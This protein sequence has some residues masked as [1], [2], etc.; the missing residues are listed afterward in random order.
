MPDE[1]LWRCSF[2]RAQ[3]LFTQ[4]DCPDGHDECPDWACTECGTAFV[5][6][7]AVT[8]GREPALAG[9]RSA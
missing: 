8:D 7:P 9:A 6:S 1:D 2:C 3:R 5:W 4:P